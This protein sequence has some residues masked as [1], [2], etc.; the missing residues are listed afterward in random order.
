M[1]IF[2]KI[3]GRDPNS[4]YDCNRLSR[5]Q[6]RIGRI[7]SRQGGGG[8]QKKR[9]RKGESRQQDESKFQ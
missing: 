4:N 3:N 8:G 1:S 5:V 7:G 6:N 2:I 9:T